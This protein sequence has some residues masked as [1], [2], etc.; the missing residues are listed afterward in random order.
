MFVVVKS[1]EVDET[2]VNGCDGIGRKMLRKPFQWLK[3][4]D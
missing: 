2:L 4:I 3:K 1:A